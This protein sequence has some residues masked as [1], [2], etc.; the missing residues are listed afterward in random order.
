MIKKTL[1][2][3]F[4]RKLLKEKR[5]WPCICSD[6]RGVTY[7]YPENLSAKFVESFSVK[8]DIYTIINNASIQQ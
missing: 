1:N 3:R 5:I 6:R 7:D 4:V 8:N 2:A